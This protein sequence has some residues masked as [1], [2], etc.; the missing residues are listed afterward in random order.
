MASVLAFSMWTSVTRAQVGEALP[1]SEQEDADGSYWVWLL[2]E[3]GG[4]FERVP[5]KEIRDSPSF[6]EVSAR[7][8]RAG[9]VAAW[10]EL[11]GLVD[12]E[13]NIVLAGR[14]LK[15]ADLEKTRGPATWYRW[16]KRRKTPKNVSRLQLGAWFEV[17]NPDPYVWISQ[18]E[19][20]SEGRFILQFSRRP[21]RMMNGADGIAALSLVGETIP[22]GTTAR[23]HAEDQAKRWMLTKAR[24]TEANGVAHIDG[25]CPSGHCRILRTVH[26]RGTTALTV[27][28]ALPT[29]L[30]GRL[31][32]DCDAWLRS[33]KIGPTSDGGITVARPR[34]GPPD[35]PSEASARDLKG[36]DALRR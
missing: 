14:Q 16:Q 29:P 15:L 32:P 1:F 5:A 2:Y 20:K 12:E 6:K 13:G 17:V 25:D 28:C 19:S 21:I 34:S 9:D 18:E 10:S 36:F 23:Q 22:P 27:A 35:L 4:P 31:M 3:K 26:V 11:I 24:I 8:R 33:A 7:E 30:A